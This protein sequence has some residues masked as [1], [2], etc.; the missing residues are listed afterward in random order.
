MVLGAQFGCPGLKSLAKTDVPT[1]KVWPFLSQVSCFCCCLCGR[2][3]SSVMWS[4]RSVSA[5]ADY[6]PFYSVPFGVV[7]YERRNACSISSVVVP[8]PFTLSRARLNMF[9]SVMTLISSGRFSS[10]SAN[11]NAAYVTGCLGR[12]TGF[13][14]GFSASVASAWVQRPRLLVKTEKKKTL[15]VFLRFGP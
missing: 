9:T 11:D 6:M 5:S 8:S 15:K 3:T 1:V 13:V 4:F 10:L 7:L 14:K 2:K 12:K